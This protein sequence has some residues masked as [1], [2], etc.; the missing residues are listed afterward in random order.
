MAASTN[1]TTLDKVKA[2]LGVSTTDDDTLISALIQSVS[3]AIEHYCGREFA[4]SE[5]TEFHDGRNSGSIVLKCRPVQSVSGVYDDC[6]RVFPDLSE[7]SSSCYV[8][9]P[10]SG[11]IELTGGLFSNGWRNVK[12]VYVAGYET[13]PAAVEQAANILIANFYNRGHSGGDGLDSESVGAYTISYNEAEWPASVKGLLFE[14][15]EYEV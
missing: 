14:F 13:V 12:V 1:L 15:R 5:R 10:E 2:Y 7:I 4:E 3:E 11:L 6:D 9:Y 8:F